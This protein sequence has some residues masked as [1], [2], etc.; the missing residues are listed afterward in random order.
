MVGV[1]F[2][3]PKNLEVGLMSLGNKD[4]MP[5]SQSLKRVGLQRVTVFEDFDKALEFAGER[6]N[7]LLIVDLRSRIEMGLECIKDLKV[8]NEILNFPVIPVVKAGDQA[9][10][11][12]ALKDYG[13]TEVVTIP[14]QTA[15]LL[16]A[17]RKTLVGFLP[18][19]MESQL[20]MVHDAL[21]Q[22]KIE[23]ASQ[24][25]ESLSEK[26]RTIRTE[27][28]LTHI[29]LERRDIDRARECLKSAKNCDPESF[30]VHIAQLRHLLL[31]Q[32]DR[33]SIEDFLT[34]M[35]Q[36]VPPKNR[37]GQIMKA[38]FKA[39]RYQDGLLISIK[40]ERELGVDQN[41][42]LWQA[43]L[44]L[45]C[46]RIETGLQFLQKFHRNGTKTIE[47]LNMLGV[48]HKKKKNLD[49]AVRAFE[50]AQR[51]NPKDFR[52]LF[53]LGLAHEERGDALRA[54]DFYERSLEIQPS[55][56]KA[57]RRLIR[58][59]PPLAAS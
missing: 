14:L 33:N 20:R 11:I 44:A 56:E 13:V 24:I 38:F 54:A 21:D 6:R 59:K 10:I 35:L 52:V 4:L 31:E 48:I 34:D 5:I 7:S 43:K 2:E 22:G 19:E 58:I 37:V 12:P 27:L 39:G 26:R 55:Y 50:E 16:Q 29:S 9:T 15:N 47:S 40:F 36:K 23:H 42:R 51:M 41:L 30:G 32:V 46:R 18:G 17:I 25:L 3:I 49:E 53:N 45:K 8:D 1:T 28:G 57:R